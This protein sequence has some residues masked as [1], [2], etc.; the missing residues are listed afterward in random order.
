MPERRDDQRREHR[1]EDLNGDE[2]EGDER[3]PVLAQALPEELPRRPREIRDDRRGDERDGQRLP[4]RV[5]AH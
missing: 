2:A 3:D 5:A 1:G 4:C